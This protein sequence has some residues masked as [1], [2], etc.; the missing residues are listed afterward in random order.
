LAD[1]P[2]PPPPPQDPDNGRRLELLR[3]VVPSEPLRL[4]F[5]TERYVK[6][7]EEVWERYIQVGRP[8]P[9]IRAKRLEEYLDAPVRIYLKMEGYTYTGSHKVNSALAWVYY[10]LRMGQ[11]RHDGDGGRAVGFGCVPCGGTL[12]G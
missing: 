9:L 3:R 7:L 5:S 12:Q 10:A 4:E 2:E 11:V 1:L 8:T 6:I